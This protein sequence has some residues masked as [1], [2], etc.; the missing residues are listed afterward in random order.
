MIQLVAIGR[1]PNVNNK[2]YVIDAPAE[3]S[4]ITEVTFGATAYC[5]SEGKTYIVNGS[6]N[7]VELDDSCPPSVKGVG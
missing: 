1:H 5:I 2:H 3:L 4:D 7:F 6:G